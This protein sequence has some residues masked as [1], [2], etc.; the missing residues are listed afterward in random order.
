MRLGRPVRVCIGLVV[1]SL[2]K[3]RFDEESLATSASPI[4]LEYRQTRFSMPCQSKY[5]QLGKCVQ[6]SLR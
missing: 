1:F 2:T 5:P 6:V 3:G 4:R